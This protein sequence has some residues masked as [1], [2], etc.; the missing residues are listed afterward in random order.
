MYKS[1]AHEKSQSK[2]NK[3]YFN[4]TV[5]TNIE[6]FTKTKTLQNYKFDSYARQSSFKYSLEIQKVQYD[7]EN[8]ENSLFNS[9]TINEQKESSTYR[10]VM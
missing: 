4:E 7:N 9:I 10:N 6:Q 1:N 2:P 5:N 3:P 8:E